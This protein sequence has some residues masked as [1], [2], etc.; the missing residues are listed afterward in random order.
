MYADKLAARDSP[1]LVHDNSP[2]GEN[3]FVEYGS[4]IPKDKKGTCV[5]ATDS[6]YNEISL[7]DFANPGFSGETGKCDFLHSF[8][9]SFPSQ[10]FHNTFAKNAVPPGNF[11]K[12]SPTYLK[13]QL[14]L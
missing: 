10:R 4:G 2:Y 9:A 7:Y 1:N 8:S 5:K 13:Y 14:I 12:L 3:L 11:I 6:W